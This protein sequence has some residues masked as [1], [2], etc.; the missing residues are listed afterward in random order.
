M[1]E[2]K[3]KLA[4]N[5]LAGLAEVF[6]TSLYDILDLLVGVECSDEDAHEIKEYLKTL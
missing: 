1:T 5:S 3:T 4:A 2:E 6:D